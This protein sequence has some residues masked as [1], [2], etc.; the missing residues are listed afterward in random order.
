M[1]AL[2]LVACILLFTVL[3]LAWLSIAAVQQSE[4]RLGARQGERVQ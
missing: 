3:W 4:Q 2:M 1:I